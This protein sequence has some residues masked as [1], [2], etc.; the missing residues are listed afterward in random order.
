MGRELKWPVLANRISS[1]VALGQRSSANGIPTHWKIALA[2]TD[3]QR[4][5]KVG[6][7]MAYAMRRIKFTLNN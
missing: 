5:S 7:F 1:Q 2:Q 6:I 3:Q 4:Q